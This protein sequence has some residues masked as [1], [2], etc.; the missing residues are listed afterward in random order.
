MTS[1]QR[2]HLG[3]G[4]RVKAARP[5]LSGGDPISA[6]SEEHWIQ[7][8]LFDGRRNRFFENGPRA[9]NGAPGDRPDLPPARS[10]PPHRSM[11]PLWPEH[12]GRRH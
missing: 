12:P 8:G 10:G 4:G 3:V 11:R 6:V 9:L 2:R 5:R 1:Q 7:L